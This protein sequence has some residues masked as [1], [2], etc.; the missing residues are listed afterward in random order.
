M[1]MMTVGDLREAL[2]DYPDDWEIIFGC[3]ELEFFRAKK[4]G[5]KLVQIEF[6]QVVGATDDGNVF[7][8]NHP[9]R[10]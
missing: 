6:S 5:V 8:E 7:I 4:R 2:K 3:K 9:R 10:S 1:T